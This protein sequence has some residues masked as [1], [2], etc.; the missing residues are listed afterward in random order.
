MM[1]KGIAKVAFVVLWGEVLRG[2]TFACLGVQGKGIVT[3]D[4]GF[5]GRYTVPGRKNGYNFKVLEIGRNG[6]SVYIIMLHWRSFG[7]KRAYHPQTNG[8]VKNTNRG[9]KH[10]LEK[11]IRNNRKDWSY[12]LDDALWAFQTAFKTPLG[13]TPFRIIYGKACHLPIELEQKAYWAIKNYNM[14]LTKACEN[15]FLQINE[16]DEMRRDAYESSISHKER[17]KG[18][19]INE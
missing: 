18:G 11:T 7:D 12:K 6:P 19:T 14:N 1:V 5:W 4:S 17:M 3:G 2:V 16:L 13:T 10:I 15:C 9:I 8:Q